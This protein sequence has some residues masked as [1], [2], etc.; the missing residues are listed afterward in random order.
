MVK[1]MRG[2]VN[3]RLISR[4]GWNSALA[5]DTQGMGIVAENANGLA[6]GEGGVLGYEFN[7][8]FDQEGRLGCL[9]ITNELQVQRRIGDEWYW[10]RKEMR[11]GS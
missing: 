7:L 3:R 8:Y 1:L 11:R 4:R 9:H 6:C 5:Y 2:I 10:F